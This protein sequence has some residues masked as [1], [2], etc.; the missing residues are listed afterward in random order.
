VSKYHKK[1]IDQSDRRILKDISTMEGERLST[2]GTKMNERHTFKS[3]H[4]QS[5]S[6][7]IIKRTTSV[8]P[9]LLGPQ[10]PRHDREETRERYCRALLTLFVPWRS[11]EDLCLLNQTWSDALAV[12]KSLITSSGNKVIENIQLLHE[13]RKQRDEHLLQVVT[14]A[15]TDDKID[16]ILL[17]NCPAENDDN[18]D[19]DA[20]E[21][22][23]MV[24]FVNENTTTACCETSN[25]REQ[26]Y[27]NDALHT[28]DNTDRF[29]L[30]TGEFGLRYI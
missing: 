20:E 9:V 30:L 24:G 26:R 5:S 10:I 21:L 15:E 6:H 1:Q 11:V 14:E 7:I 13:C 27:L 16:P 17:P 22:L 19:Y 8:V 29:A 2:K 18:D 4:P 23:Q 28:I 25:T 3:T 12:R